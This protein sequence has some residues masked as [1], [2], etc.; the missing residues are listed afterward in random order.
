MK[1]ETRQ[2]QITRHRLKREFDHRLGFY[3]AAA[4]LLV[5]LSIIALILF[6]TLYPFRVL[7]IRNS[8]VPV[9][10]ERV[11]AGKLVY[12]LHNYCKFSDAEGL[13]ERRIV[14]DST[15]LALPGIPERTKAEC[16]NEVLVPAVVPPQARPGTY[17]IHHKVTYKV[18]P[19]KSLVYEWDSQPFRVVEPD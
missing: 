11:E 19:L 18:N 9:V 16:R 13:L 14:S 8:P 1:I 3:I 5:S 17:R 6:W 10:E 2:E 12:A 15:S 7:E 4:L